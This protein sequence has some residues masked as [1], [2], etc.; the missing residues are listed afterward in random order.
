MRHMLGVSLRA[1]LKFAEL[2]PGEYR[3]RPRRA[4]VSRGPAG[5][6][7]RGRLRH[8]LADRDQH[9]EAQ[10]VKPQIIRASVAGKPDDMPEQLAD[11]YRFA[12]AVVSGPGMKICIA[13]A[14]ANCMA[15][16]GW[17]SWRWRSRFA[18]SFPLRSS[19]WGCRVAR[20]YTCECRS[21]RCSRGRLE[22]PSRPPLRPLRRLVK[23]GGKSRRDLPW[24][25]IRWICASGCWPIV[26]RRWRREPSP[27]SI[28]SANRGCVA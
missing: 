2:L 1:F 24:I 17:S 13:N 6:T 26:T 8:V 12:K 28:A 20:R 19:P 11:V 14:F 10:K 22:R 25:V 7:A 27:R 3:P 15:K 16:K 23:T 21:R 4:A 9:G 5:G 18:A